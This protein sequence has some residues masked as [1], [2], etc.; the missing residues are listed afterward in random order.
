MKWLLLA[1]DFKMEKCTEKREKD[2]FGHQSMKDK[3]QNTFHPINM[4]TQ[5]TSQMVKLKEMTLS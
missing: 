1:K 5:M 2:N 4:E 3:A